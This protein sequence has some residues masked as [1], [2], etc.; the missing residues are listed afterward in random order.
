MKL[1]RPE[2]CGGHGINDLTQ[3]GLR[4]Q[5]GTED[6]LQRIEL[7][8]KAP[9]SPAARSAPLEPHAHAHGR[10]AAA[11]VRHGIG[12]GVITHKPRRRIVEH[13]LVGGGPADADH[14]AAARRTDGRE[15][16]RL[17]YT[18]G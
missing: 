5:I 13:D 10:R 18:S 4:A 9:G 15:G 11:V 2:T 8:A 6:L 17:R 3:S 7:E 1:L 12:E 16:D 14:T